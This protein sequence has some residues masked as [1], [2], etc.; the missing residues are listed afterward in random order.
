MN[1]RTAGGRMT[2]YILTAG[3]ERV[4]SDVTPVTKPVGR[5]SPAQ[6]LSSDEYVTASQRQLAVDSRALWVRCCWGCCICWLRWRAERW[7]HSK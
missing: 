3:R 6:C 2:L 1:R 7:V 5:E 4:R